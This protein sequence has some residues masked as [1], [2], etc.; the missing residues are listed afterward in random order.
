MKDE[1]Q[2]NDGGILGETSHITYSSISSNLITC[3]QSVTGLNF[4]LGP[5]NFTKVSNKLTDVRP[6]GMNSSAIVIIIPSNVYI[7][8]ATDI[9][10][11]PVDRCYPS[12]ELMS[13]SGEIGWEEDEEDEVPL[14]LSEM[15]KNSLPVDH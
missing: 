12:C 4:C 7:H 15:C 14:C 3:C 5:I 9:S 8:V 11:C 1:N 10:T 13:L 6:R 2:P